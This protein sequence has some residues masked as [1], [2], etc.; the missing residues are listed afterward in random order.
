MVIRKFLSAAFFEGRPRTFWNESSIVPGTTMVPSLDK[1]MHTSWTG[2]AFLSDAFRMSVDLVAMSQSSQK[3]MTMLGWFRM[4]LIVTA[5]C[6]GEGASSQPSASPIR[7]GF[8]PDSATSKTAEPRI[9]RCWCPASV[10]PF[11]EIAIMTVG[12]RT[13][14]SSSNPIAMI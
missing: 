13:S 7:W 8:Y 14:S 10:F 4:I 1:V 3:R 2:R 6:T 11:G 5:I 12:P 9:F